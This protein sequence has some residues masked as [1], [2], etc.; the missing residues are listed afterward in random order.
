MSAELVQIELD[1]CGSLGRFRIG[2]LDLLEKISPLWHTR[3][4]RLVRLASLAGLKG[5]A[6]GRHA[7]KIVVRAGRVQIPTPTPRASTPTPKPRP[8]APVRLT[9][10]RGAFSSKA[11]ATIG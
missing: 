3:Q 10:D 2:D 6:A 11:L 1:R 4:R 5:A 9:R 8:S 7:R